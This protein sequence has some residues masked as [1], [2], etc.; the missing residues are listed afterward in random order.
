[1]YAL[2]GLAIGFVLAGIASVRVGPF[3]KKAEIEKIFFSYRY[4][5]II[6]G[7]TFCTGFALFA[8]TIIFCTIYQYEGIFFII[9]TVVI[10][11]LW[12]IGMATGIPA[13]YINGFLS[14]LY[15][16]SDDPRTARQKHIYQD[17]RKAYN[18]HQPIVDPRIGDARF[19]EVNE[20]A[21]A[22]GDEKAIAFMASIAP[23]KEES[24]SEEVPR[25]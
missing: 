24:V 4:A 14:K 3:C 19:P 21:A 15:M 12:I 16:G 17:M 11:L 5:N 18:H 20:R 2:I 1:M 23:K 6:G 22:Q 25:G 8:L 7:I 10:A 13:A 9:A